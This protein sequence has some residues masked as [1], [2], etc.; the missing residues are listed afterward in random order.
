MYGSGIAHGFFYFADRFLPKGGGSDWVD[1]FF[2]D[3]VRRWQSQK[4]LKAG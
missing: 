2:V 4:S 3:L 1:W